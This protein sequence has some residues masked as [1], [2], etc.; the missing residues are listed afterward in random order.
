VTS[1]DCQ[2]STGW[3]ETADYM[4]T[5]ANVENYVDLALTKADLLI[6]DRDA[7]VEFDVSISGLEGLS[8]SSLMFSIDG[9]IQ[10]FGN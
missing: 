5:G 7:Y 6:D 8:K 10:W 1:D 9:I 3:I 2:L 4:F